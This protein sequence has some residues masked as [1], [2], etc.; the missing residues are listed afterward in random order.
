MNYTP[1]HTNVYPSYNYLVA[2]NAFLKQDIEYKNVVMF[3]QQNKINFLEQEYEKLQHDAMRWNKFKQIIDAQK[4]ELTAQQLQ[5]IVDS[6][7]RA[8]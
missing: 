5:N 3:E 2:E 7:H 6:G 4:G 8:G 1:I